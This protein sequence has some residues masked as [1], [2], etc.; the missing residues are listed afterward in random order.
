MG[1]FEPALRR[2]AAVLSVVMVATLV[3]T[4]QAHAQ[5][6]PTPQ[7]TPQ[8]IAAAPNPPAARSAADEASARLTARLTKQRVE[9][10]AARTE[11]S[12]TYANPDG[13]LTVE[14]FT[15]PIRYRD[16]D[17]WKPVDISLTAM[18]DGTVTARSHRRGLRIGGAGTARGS[19]THTEL[20]A[21]GTGEEHISLQWPGRLPQPQ[22]AGETVTY[23]AVLPGADLVVAATRTGAE[24]FLVLKERPTAPLSYRLRLQAPGLEARRT[25]GGGVELVDKK[26]KIVA[27]VPA[28]TMWDA[29]THPQSGEHTHRGKVDM[30]IDGKDLVVTPDAAFLADPATTYPVTVDPAVN[31]GQAFDTF[32]QEGYGTDQSGATELKIG[33]N[34]S[35]QRARSFIT[36]KTP[37]IAGKKI[38]SATL[39]LWNFHSWSCN[40]RTW[41]VWSADR[42]STSSRWPGPTMSTRYATS[43]QTKGYGSGC[44]DGWV[45]ANITSLAQY[46]A[47]NGWSESGMGLK[48]ADETDPYG[49]KRFNSGNAASNVPYIAVTYNSYPSTPVSTWTAPNSNYTVG[50]TTTHWVNTTTPQLRAHVGDPDGGNVRGLFDVYDAST[51]LIDN[52]YG[53][54]VA[55]G[56]FSSTANLAAG[57]LADGKTYTVRA[58]G[59]DGSLTSKA[60]QTYTFVVDTTKPAA[61]A[62][63][64]TSHP[65]DGGWYGDAGK[66]A[67]FAVTP[68]GPDTGWIAYKLDDGAVTTMATTGAATTVTV[69]P[70]T[71]GPHTFAAYT[72]DKAGNVSPTTSHEFN[73]GAGA[74]SSPAD[75]ERTARRAEL[76]ATGRGEFDRVTFQWRRADTD[77][78]TDIPTANVV[79]A[80]GQPIASWPVTATVSGGSARVSGLTWNVVDQLGGDAAV[81]VRAVFAN[82]SGGSATTPAEDLVADRQASGAATEKAGPGTVNLL[83]GDFRLEATEASM[84]G[85]SISRTASSRD[86][87]LGSRVTGQT[88]PFGPEWSAGGVSEVAESEYA[89]L[90]ETSASSV[91]LTL[92]DG[93]PIQFTK[94]SSGWKP[95]EG[96]E[97]LTLTGAYTLKD[98]DGVVTTFSKPSGATVYLPASTTPPGDNNVTRYVYETV[99]GVTRLRAI[100]APTSAVADLATDCALPAPKPGCR[101][102]EL[103][104]AGATAGGDYAGRLSKVLFHDSQTPVAVAQYAYDASGRLIEA[105]DPR[106]SPPLKTVYGYDAAGRVTSLTPPGE[107]PWTFVYGKAGDPSDPNDGRLLAVS[108]PALVP[109]TVDQV[110]G[111]SRTSIVYDVPLDKASGGP[112]D[113][114]P[115]HTATWGQSDNPTDATAVFPADQVPA[116]HTGAQASWTRASVTYLD[117]S[118]REVNDLTPGGYLSTTEHDKFGNTVRSLTAGNRELA[119]GTSA[120]LAELGISGL[121]TAERAELLS[122]RSVFDED[123]QR[124]LEEYG[125]LHLVTVQG[126]VVAA[127]SH[128]VNT[129]DEGRPAGAPTKDLVTKVAV[130]AKVLGKESEPDADVR[131]TTTEYDWQLGKATKTVKDAGGLALATTTAYDTE[132]RPTRS[133]LPK[134]N[135]AATLVTTYYTAS[136][137]APCGGKPEWAGLVCRTAPAGAIVG[138]GSN[139][140]EMPVKVTTYNRFGDP[141]TVAETANGVTRTT[142]VT[143]DAGGRPLT[144]WIS[145]GLGQA[146]PASNVYYSPDTGK[147]L[148]KQ[149]I[150][151]AGTVI[152]RIVTAYDRLGRTISYTDADGG[153][154]TTSY[155]L[156]DRRVKVTDT[157]PST[158]TYA[159]DHAKE[160]RGL[161][162]SLTDSVAGTFT[163]SYD[164][165]GELAG[166]DFPGGVHLAVVEDEIGA[167]VGRVFT[168]DGVE[169]PI[170]DEQVLESVHGQWITHARSDSGADREYGYDKAGRLTSVK[171]SVADRC[172]L[173]RYSVDDNSNRTRLAVQAADLSC[174]AADDAAATITSY[175]YDSGDRLVGDGIAYDAL[176]RTTSLPGGR[177]L[178][179]HVNDLVH[180]QKVGSST[181]TWALDAADRIRSF[182]TDTGSGPAT[183]VN[184]YGSD[185]DSPDWVKEAAGE[186]T[187]NVSG[188]DGDLAAVTSASGPVRL[189]LTTLHGDIGTE[190]ELGTGVATVVDADEYGV[191]RSSARR[192]GWLGGKQRSAETLDGVM[193]MGVRLYDPSL[194]RFLQLDPVEGGSANAYE[195]CMADPVNCTDLDGK[196]A[197]LVR[198]GVQ[199]CIRWCAR[200]GRAAWGAARKYGPRAWRWG[201]RWG[202]R[203]YRGAYRVAHYGRTWTSRGGYIGGASGLGYCGYRRAWRSCPRYFAYGA[204]WGAFGGAS[205][206]TSYGLYRGARYGYRV[207]KRWGRIFR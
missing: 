82:A 8:P 32:V 124:E 23:P 134:G 25:D 187:R 131:V 76:G 133:T 57:K 164:A 139:P 158:T 85:L 18:T 184:H 105:W 159:Y 186:I 30:T 201:S 92:V 10:E 70:A 183:T 167:D 3:D 2:I 165:D 148:E 177:T 100:I 48:A 110:Q 41:E 169:G 152:E 199:A 189:Q 191:S 50:T 168:K 45:S 190:L 88:S 161:P 146:L 19:R 56:G 127:R 140:T 74:L 122:T 42:A 163:A 193:L 151:A 51:L 113:L 171:E 154:T 101:V 162:V 53:G 126:T 34:G 174:P 115:Q 90:R 157:A 28:P 89:S 98:A 144:S 12:S 130:G 91:E 175:A 104:Y 1:R 60:Y 188:I 29:L 142:H 15:G 75:G 9:I 46:W 78:W 40:A 81:Q 52:V 109:G 43:T 143:Y 64:S 185:S 137:T 20:I 156:L 135:D 117:A 206:G 111:E 179:Y 116:A 114:R 97:E 86:P 49:W 61:P 170:L 66:A 94:T 37:G 108:R 147:V 16:G 132:G 120:R 182:T 59:N 21:L 136:G 80:N 204:G 128:T 103:V 39:N 112:A 125:P 202:R 4:W 141:A 17:T 149:R 72:I 68:A 33:N 203:T 87:K 83:T 44:A 24:Q 119:L 192:Y 22:V 6:A 14:T 196:W 195:Y 181:M 99:S 69:T 180:R 198:L 172:T 13:S 93:T 27:T 73:V 35:G 65:A 153:V 123:G 96:A 77:A 129:Y 194:G 47:D 200:G 106:I 84:F 38:L 176:G 207:Y 95:E 160:P 31:L 150:D 173:R 155:D 118:G 205:W 178:E 62:V 67:T 71:P 5:P 58:W 166:G 26:N 107:K 11:T 102:L 79:G 54:Y 7:N 63:A 55:S 121:G 145:G 138:G 197:F 36:W